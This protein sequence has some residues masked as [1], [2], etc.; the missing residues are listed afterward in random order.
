M[1]PQTGNEAQGWREEVP[2]SRSD[3]NVIKQTLRGEGQLHQ[4]GGGEGRGGGGGLGQKQEC[5]QDYC[6]DFHVR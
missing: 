4:H 5:T 1:K 6:N 3:L 2:C